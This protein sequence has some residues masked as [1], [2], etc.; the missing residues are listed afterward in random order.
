M[1][2]T[3]LKIL[4]F[5]FFLISSAYAESVPQVSSPIHKLRS[6]STSYSVYSG[7]EKLWKIHAR[8]VKGS[9]Q[10]LN[11]FHIKGALYR[12]QKTAYYLISPLAVLNLLTGDVF[13]PEGALLYG[14]KGE[15]VQVHWLVW[16]KDE[17]KF[18]GTKGVRIIR[19][20]SILQGE[21]LILEKNFKDLILQ[22]HVKVK[23]IQK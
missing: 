8:S 5:L 14:R 12:D 16:D 2:N 6:E 13:F 22:G 9:S 1:N 4:C 21:N 17:K 10:K 20:H 7:S 23:L 18:I 15:V 19:K 3:V 11:A